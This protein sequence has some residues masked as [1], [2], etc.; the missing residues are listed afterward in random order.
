M[1]GKFVISLDFE[2]H[3]GGAEKWNLQSKETYFLNTRKIIPEIL[4]LFGQN[5][6]RA[7][8]ATVG[9]LFAKNKE[10]MEK[11][12]PV[13]KPTYTNNRLSYYTYF[14]QVGNDELEDPF[15]FG[16]SLIEK[17]IQTKGQEVSS[18]TFSHYY[19]N[20][21]GQTPEQFEA[22][23]R[24]AQ[25]IA[26]ENFNIKLES[27]VFP[28]NQYNNSYLK[29]VKRQG[30]KIVRTNPNVWF[31]QKSFGKITPVFRALDTLLSISSTLTFDEID[32]KWQNEV[33]K[34]PASRFFRPYREKEKSIQ[35]RKLNRIKSEMTYAAKNNRI[36]HLWWH[37]HN[38]GED[39][40]QN[41]NQLKEI[42]DH[43][44]YLNEKYNF[45]SNSMI[46]FILKNNY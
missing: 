24:T 4:E 38:F 34:L 16:A 17:I 1:A 18:H 28:R 9:F 5:N 15:H 19:C 33:L 20:E 43:F 6:I 45:Q 29:V 8:W 30:I 32:L 2:L 7:T 13:L 25:A 41:L 36:Y 31:W 11:F 3:W 26:L 27:L 37:P 40:E 23:L 14:D 39:V 44:N 35:S 22:D 12:S 46:D 10:Q 42:I 21:E